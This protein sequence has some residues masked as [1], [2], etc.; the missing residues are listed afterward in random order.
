MICILAMILSQKVIRFIIDQV[1]KEDS[2]NEW[3]LVIR[4]HIH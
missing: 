3:E 2:L 4:L 1:K